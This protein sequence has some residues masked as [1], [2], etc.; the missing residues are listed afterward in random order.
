[1]EK[2]LGRGL[3]SLLGQAGPETPTSEVE[4]RR[5]RPNPHQPRKEFDAAA[6]EDLRDSLKR[7]GML[8]PVV[9][10]RAHDDFELIS[11]ERR[12]RAAQLAG[13]ERIPAVIRDGVSEGDMLELALVENLQ[14]QDLN[15]IERA[16]GFRSMMSRLGLTQDQVAEKVGLKRATVAN[17]LR[18]LELPDAVRQAVSANLI[19]MGHAKA[20]AGLASS[21]DMLDLLEESVRKGLSVRELEDRV[22][23]QQP[24]PKSELQPRASAPKR[25]AWIA[26]LE[27]RLSDRLGA[28]VSIQNA[29]GYRGRIA[30]EYFDRAE[31]D[32]LVERLAPRQTL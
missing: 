15:P 32:G 20:I 6:L 27:R 1:M 18:L 22:R 29:S 26:D 17:H 23:R 7:H 14:R 5:I 3:G 24:E 13:I 25:E 30:I 19:Q 2:R 31:L 8:Q 11:G 10:R 21:K 9:L 28:K 4:L 12:W 16:Q